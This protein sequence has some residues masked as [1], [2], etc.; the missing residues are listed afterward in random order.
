[1]TFIKG[2]PAT[3]HPT[4]TDQRIPAQMAD[5]MTPATLGAMAFISR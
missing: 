5:P 2:G 1:M 3:G 4:I